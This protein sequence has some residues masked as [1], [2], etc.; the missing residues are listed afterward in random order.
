MLLLLLLLLLIANLL[1]LGLDFDLIALQRRRPSRVGRGPLG[2][3]VGR[4][5][6]GRVSVGRHVA[7]S[8]F[9]PLPLAGVEDA[10]AP[11]A[12]DDA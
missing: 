7:V 5:A 11:A 4:P 6:I 3:S 8:I 12:G 2:R 10:A 1:I 9:L